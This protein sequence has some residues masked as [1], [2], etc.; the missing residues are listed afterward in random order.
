METDIILSSD[1]AAQTDR[2]IEALRPDRVF[3]LCDET[4]ARLCRPLLSASQRLATAPLISIGAGD[5]HK[6]LDTLA[7][8]WRALSEGGASRRSLLVC[9]G[10]GMV[11]DLGGFAAATFKR[12]MACLNIPTTLLAMVDA[13]VGGKTG[14]NFNGLKNEVGAFSNPR[15]VI[16]D[17]DFL[18]TLDETNLRSGY[19]EMLKHGLISGRELWAASLDFD[20]AA[21]DYGRLQ[22]MVAENIRVKSDI[23]RQD[24]HEHGLRKALN[25]GHTAGHA[26][27]AL[28]LSRQR[29]VLHG[30]AVAW[31]LV[32]ELYLS[33]L[34]TGFPLN[35][36]RQTTAYIRDHYGRFAFDCDD[37]DHLLRLMSHDKKNVGGVINFTLLGAPGDIRLDNTATHE[38]ICESFDFLR[39]SL[40]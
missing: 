16:I 10:G 27:E 22:T 40:G 7:A 39:E 24:P 34:K 32:C 36:L 31:G 1:L 21:P 28:A 12:G 17:T 26:L 30:Y 23:V 8:V 35:D 25:L 18:R 11:T 29:P 33:H 37:Y 38:E 4:T 13:A 19:A 15:A 2:A 9:L 3:L 6:E 14:I 20:I 5:A